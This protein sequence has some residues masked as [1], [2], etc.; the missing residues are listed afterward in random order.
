MTSR[1][2]SQA[3][4][5]LADDLRA[6]TDDELITLVRRRPDL[7]APT[8]GDIGQLAGRSVTAASTSRALD[9]L[10]RFGLQVV[11]ATVV[12]DEPFTADDVV[13]LFPDTMPD[14][15]TDQ[16]RDLV[17][18]ALV[19]GTPEAWRPTVAVRETIGR[20]PAGL[21]PALAQLGGGDVNELV[22]AMKVAPDDA[23]EVL[24]ALTWQ[25]PT[26]RVQAADREVTAENAKTPVEWLL[27]RGVLRPL[28]RATVVLPRELSLHLRGGRLHRTVTTT[29]PPGELHHHDPAVIDRL[30][31]GTADEFVRQ[32]GSL[33][34]RWGL[35]A[36]GVLRSGGL[37]VRELRAAASALD[38]D[39]HHAALV[40]ETAWAAG[41]LAASGELDDQWLPTPEYDVWRTKEVAQ[42]WLTLA[43]ASLE[44]S[45]VASLVGTGTNDGRVNALTAEVE[46]IAAPDIRRWVLSDLATFSEGTAVSVESMVQR[47]EWLRPRRGGRLRDELVRWTLHEASAIGLCARGAMSSA[48]RHLVAGD[49]NRAQVALAELLPEPV[50]HVLLQADLTAVAPGPLEDEVGR[51]LSLMADVESYGGATVYRFTEASIRRTLDAGRTASECV[52][53]LE[54]ISRTPVPQPL[55]YL[56]DDVAR[57]HGRLR[58]GA[59]SSYLR[60]DDPAVLDELVAGRGAETLRLRRLAPT[61]MVSPTAADVLIERLRELGLAPAA[62]GGDG[63]VLTSRP[64]ERRTGPRAKPRRLVSDPPA[65][66]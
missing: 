59:A 12:C 31:A 66:S 8:P 18:L 32:V 19:W 53:F 9:H 39:E 27:A 62:E 14:V 61:V 51:A 28:D 1:R 48:A 15:V 25:N 29:P 37:G 38:V 13:T 45:H 57:R 35:V 20:F 33:L 42:R 63:A 3:P 4:R 26:G 11:E 65:P 64:D 17:E 56:I 5:S 54:G 41:L 30:C 21:G 44:S 50:D 49:A 55:S 46:R 23:R 34:E 40:V 10:T 22:S 60:C 43:S 47:H 2:A 24:E 6:R 16:L 7:A 36:P 58:V 52:A